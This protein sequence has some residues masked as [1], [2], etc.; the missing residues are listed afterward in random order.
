MMKP[1]CQT[2]LSRPQG[3]PMWPQ[4]PRA[5]IDDPVSIVARDDLVIGCRQK[6][7]QP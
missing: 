5:A 6:T 2:R 4:S 1:R 7:C 3:E